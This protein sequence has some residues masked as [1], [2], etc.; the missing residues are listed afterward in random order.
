MIRG[1]VRGVTG[2]VRTQ[3]ARGWQLAAAKPAGDLDTLPT[4]LDSLRW[5]A[6]P[7]PGTAARALRAA[8]AWSWDTPRDFDAE[9]WWWRV[10]LGGASG[11]LAIDGIATLW[12][13]WIDGELV[14]RGDSMWRRLTV[15]LDGAKELVVRC[16]ALAPE[17]AKK[18]PRPRWKV[19]MLEQQQLRWFRTTLL[20]RTP[21]WSPPCPPVGPWRPVW[22]EERGALRVGEVTVRAQLVDDT[23]FV[24]VGAQ[25][26]GATE[27]TLVVTRGAG[28]EGRGDSRE[29]ARHSVA[30]AHE[31]GAWVGSLAIDA[32][33][34]WWPHT[35]GEPARYAVAIET[36][37]GTVDLGHIGFRTIEVRSEAGDFQVVVNGVPVFC[38]GACWTPLDVVAFSAPADAYRAAVVQLVDAGMNMLRIGGTMTYEDDAFYDALDEHGVLLW[39]DVMCANMDYPDALATQLAAEVGDEFARLQA[40]PCVAVICG[41]SEGEQQ[42]AMFGVT[43]EVREAWSAAES[44]IARTVA[45]RLP[46]ACYVRS[47]ATEGAFPHASNV[48]PSSYYGVGAYL[49]PLEDA[50]R[51]EVRFA[52]ECLAFAN[53]PNDPALPRVHTPEW[54]QR[55]PRDL[56]AGWD[57]D[58]V[59]DHYVRLL[60]GVDPAALR[61]A[62]HERY[63]ALGRAATG[64]VMARTFAEWRRGRSRTR[65]GLIWFLRDLWPGAGWGV[66]DA[67]G[68]PKQAYY[69]LRRAL[70]PIAI[71]FTDEGTNG[72]ALHAVNDR[73]APLAARIELALWRNGETD[74]GRT[75]REIELPAHGAVELNAAAQFEHWIDLSWAYRFGPPVAQVIHARLIAEGRDGAPG[76]ERDAFW[77]PAGL[78]FAREASVGLTASA[79]ASS[80]ESPA[81]P[82]SYVVELRAAR[83]AQSVAIDAP[84]FIPDDDGFH[85]APGQ[86]RRVQ[87]RAVEDPAG[88]IAGGKPPRPLRGTVSALNA[89]ATARIETDATARIETP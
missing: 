73:P 72:L 51:A 84:G 63:L 1:R 36:N 82:A 69:A 47:S 43:G 30:L 26:E 41:S 32:P 16:R 12:D 8:G 23:G 80:S 61:Y 74:V 45:L 18:R 31:G 81:R 39:H 75:A 2:T 9:D 4:G 50:R 57:F 56:G 21:G 55:A 58:D 86:S 83:F 7:V 25:L 85:L 76:V 77:F 89:D 68:L 60:Y 65:G 88:D 59:R 44:A 42:A 11:T 66:I 64:E 46:D 33:V 78:A 15:S 28:A 52:S 67:N 49:R 54:K 53:I 48:G 5:I 27:A 37:A 70:D 17:L 10:S 13:A 35:H 62:D 22:L 14:G 40:R 24:Q 3:L 20:G 79:V 19:P 34:R 71:A 29:P 87:L 6:A 38:R